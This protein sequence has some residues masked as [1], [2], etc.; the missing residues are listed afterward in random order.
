MTA[1]SPTAPAPEAAVPAAE[2]AAAPFSIPLDGAVRL[3]HWAVIDAAGEDAAAFLHGQLSQDVQGLPADQARLAAYCT[4]KGRMLASFVLL[5]PAAER[6]WLACS[7]DVLP[8]TLKRLRMFV[9]RAKAKLEDATATLTV[10]GLCGQ[11]AAAWLGAQAPGEPWAVVAHGDARIVRLPP[12]AGTPAAAWLWIGPAEQAQAVLD[13]LPALPAEA[14]PWLEV[15]AGLP[16]ITAAT[17]EQFV[18]QMINLELIGG[19]NFKK[20]CYPG[21]E[22]VA[23]SQYLGKLKRRMVRLDANA[24]LQAGQ[25]VFAAADPAQPAGMVVNAAPSPA[26]GWSALV[27]LKLAAWVDGRLHA[28]GVDGPEL[29]RAALPYAVPE[30]DTAADDP[31]HEPAVATAPTQPAQSAG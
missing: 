9:L 23:R 29:R 13:A 5:R 1:M 10:L 19:V 7:A 12:A 2:A 14:W 31:A 24:P 16:R 27:E 30:L 28:G 22:V 15:A 20:G 17:V 4:A 3:S 18:P 25:E 21:Q 11:R 6:V 8:A 26:G